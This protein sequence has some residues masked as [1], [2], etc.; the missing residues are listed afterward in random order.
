MKKNTTK[1]QRQKT[2]RLRLNRETIQIL[3][4]P[5]LLELARGEAQNV[6]GL[7]AGGLGCQIVTGSGTGGC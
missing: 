3:D 1:D 2:H 7:S 4:D 5:A 6:T